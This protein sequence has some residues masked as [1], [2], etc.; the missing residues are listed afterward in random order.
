MPLTKVSTKRQI[1]IPVKVFKALDLEVGDL[2]EINVE[3]G[4]GVLVP[5]KL[6]AKTSVPKLTQ[7]EQ[8]ILRAVQKKISAIAND[9]LNSKGL[10]TGEIKVGVK[11]GLIDPEQTWYWTE[12]WQKKEREAERDI[13]EGD[14][15]EKYDDVDTALAAL[16][17]TKV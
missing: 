3:N 5:Q 2:L 11:V 7:A 4:K 12:E 9:K 17:K 6:T 10:T 16:K 13:Q 1:T 15:S 14:L 8:K